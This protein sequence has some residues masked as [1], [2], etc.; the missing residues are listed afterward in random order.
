MFI[1]THIANMYPSSTVGNQVF[2]TIFISSL[3]LIFLLS[4]IHKIS[5]FKAISQKFLSDHLM[6]ILTKHSSQ[7]IEIKNQNGKMEPNSS[8]KQCKPPPLFFFAVIR[9]TASIK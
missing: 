2:K 6:S 9:A 4:F 3:F 7:I 1:H 8:S 5:N